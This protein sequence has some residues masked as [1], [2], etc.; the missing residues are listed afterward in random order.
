[1]SSPTLRLAHSRT[2]P[3]G[4]KVS[5]V[6]EIVLDVELISWSA[7][8]P[9]GRLGLSGGVCGWKCSSSTQSVP[10]CL[11]TDFAESNASTHGLLK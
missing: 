8:T 5:P 2:W 6:R 10:A 7:A 11:G 4:E 9:G 3:L 1:M